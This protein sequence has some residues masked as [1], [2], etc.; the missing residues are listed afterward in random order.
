MAAPRTTK[1]PKAKAAQRET[2]DSV[3]TKGVVAL[4]HLRL[5]D[6]RRRLENRDCYCC[7]AHGP[8][9]PGCEIAE[10]LR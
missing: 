2:T 8:C 7:R 9:T 3:N 6:E 4:K 1:A 5:I 10:A